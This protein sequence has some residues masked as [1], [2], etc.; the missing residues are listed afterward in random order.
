[1]RPSLGLMK[2]ERNIEIG[3][4]G[5]IIGDFN[6][7]FSFVG[8]LCT[9][10][11]Q[12]SLLGRYFHHIKKRNLP[13]LLFYEE[14]H[15]LIGKALKYFYMLQKSLITCI[16]KHGSKLLLLIFKKNTIS[17][18]LLYTHYLPTRELT[19]TN[20]QFQKQRIVDQPWLILTFPFKDE[21][22]LVISD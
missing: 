16:C 17:I 4:L 6:S 21:F 19:L 8:Q 20:L 1:M 7:L 13:C 12:L 2:G 5:Q 10:A 9:F 15:S 14:L 3:C 18:V 11:R 22:S